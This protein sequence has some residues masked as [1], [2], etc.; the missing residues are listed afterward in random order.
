VKATNEREIAFLGEAG[1]EVVHDLGL[2]LMGDG[3][4]FSADHPLA[5]GRPDGRDVAGPRPTAT[6]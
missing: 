6:S 1:Y 3:D 2:G 4:E 5:M